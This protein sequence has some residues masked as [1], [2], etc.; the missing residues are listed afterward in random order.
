M[1]RSWMIF[2][3][4][5]LWWFDFFVFYVVLSGVLMFL[6]YCVYMTFRTFL[7]LMFFIIKFMFVLFWM[8]L[9]MVFGDVCI[10]GVLIYVLVLMVINVLMFLSVDGWMWNFRR[11]KRAVMI[12]AFSRTNVLNMLLLMNRFFDVVCVKVLLR[13]MLLLYNVKWLL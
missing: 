3:D 7:F 6:T 4:F 10:F 8:C 2:V 13:S 5:G 12:Y 1:F 11:V 9:C